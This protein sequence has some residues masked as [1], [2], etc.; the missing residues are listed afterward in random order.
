MDQ[1]K[2]RAAIRSRLSNLAGLRARADAVDEKLQEAAQKELE[3]VSQDLDK[4]RPRVHLD[5]AAADQ[6]QALILDRARLER[7][8]R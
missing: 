3:R 2:V 6:Y 7:I 5:E 8:L 4:L 1:A